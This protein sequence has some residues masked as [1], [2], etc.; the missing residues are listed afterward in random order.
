MRYEGR[1]Y[2]KE[3]TL[4]KIYVV[5]HLEG[6]KFKRFKIKFKKESRKKKL[7]I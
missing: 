4:L 5:G 6:S 2:M 7:K 1:N 3:E